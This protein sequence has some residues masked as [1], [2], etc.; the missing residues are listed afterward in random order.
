MKHWRTTFGLALATGLAVGAVAFA[1][2]QEKKKAAGPP[3]EKAAMEAMQ[4]AATPGEAH[5][6]LEAVVGTFDTKVKTWM[7]PSKPPEES[8]GTSENTWVLGNR[9]VQ[10]KYQGT[11]MGQPFSGMGYQGYDN[12]TKKY[13]GTWMDSMSTG[14]MR[15]TGQADKSGKTMTMTGSAADPVT[16]KMVNLTEKITVKD[17]DHHSFEMWAPGPDGKPVKMMEI[18]YTRKK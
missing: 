8:T 2:D 5:K 1:A 6:K 13:V 15:T 11:M 9:Y 12:V 18:E 10:M 16:G 4:K 14:I 7:D 3:D 17:N